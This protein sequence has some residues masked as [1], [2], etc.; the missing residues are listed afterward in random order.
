MH[1][2]RNENAVLQHLFVAMQ[3]ISKNSKKG[4]KMV[5]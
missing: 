1:H 5:I 3:Q 2:Y 4:S